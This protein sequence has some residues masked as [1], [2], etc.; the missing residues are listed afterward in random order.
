MELSGLLAAILFL[1]LVLM[2]SLFQLAL[3]FGVAWGEWTLGGRW[4][5]RLPWS[6]RLISAISL[7]LLLGFAILI[8]VRVGWLALGSPEAVRAWCWGVVAYCG[9]GVVANSIT[10]SE[11]ERKLWLPVVTLMFISSLIVNLSA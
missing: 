8:S 2:V 3:I 9:L 7:L 10:R 5:G 4:R 11:R 1:A 6:A